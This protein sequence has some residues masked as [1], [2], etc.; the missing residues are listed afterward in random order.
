[1]YIWIDVDPSEFDFLEFSKDAVIHRNVETGPGYTAHRVYEPIRHV[2]I[3]DGDAL[4][5]FPDGSE[6]EHPSWTL[7]GVVGEIPEV[8]AD[9]VFENGKCVWC[10]VQR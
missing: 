6:I 4:V 2:T 5:V 8:P 7:W 1:M 10:G 3:V 9:H